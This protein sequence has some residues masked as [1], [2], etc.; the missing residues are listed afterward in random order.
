MKRKYILLAL[1]IVVLA[2]FC[3]FLIDPQKLTPDHPA[4]K[5]V[6]YSIVD[7]AAV[8]QREDGRYNYELT[9]YT[10]Q[11]NTKKLSFTASKQ[12]QKNASL[13]L[14]ATFL[15]GVTHWEEISPEELPEQVKQLIV[16]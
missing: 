7:H 9:G 3:F 15:R 1:V 8:G 14:F 12:L 10:A 16:K 6:Y 13:K 2:C 5:K 4:G 11:G